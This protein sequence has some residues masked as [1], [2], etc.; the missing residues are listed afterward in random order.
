MPAR[1]LIKRL[2][3]RGGSRHT[4]ST[5]RRR[6]QRRRRRHARNTTRK[7]HCAAN[8]SHG[9]RQIPVLTTIAPIFPMN[10]RHYNRPGLRLLMYP[11]HHDRISFPLMEAPHRNRTM[12]IRMQLRSI[13]HL[14]AIL[15]ALRYERI[16]RNLRTSSCIAVCMWIYILSHYIRL[17]LYLN[18][19]CNESSHLHE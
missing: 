8:N 5:R 14:K 2:K 6:R 11:I 18:R 3:R 16:R 13:Q 12:T 7:Q 17:L 15:Y 9:C 1:F 4:D 19:S 10:F